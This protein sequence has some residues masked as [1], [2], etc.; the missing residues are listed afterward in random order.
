VSSPRARDYLLAHG[1]LRVEGSAVVW[2]G[3]PTADHE[4]HLGVFRSLAHP[5]GRA[6]SKKLPLGAPCEDAYDCSPG[7]GGCYKRPGEPV[8]YC[9]SFC[10]QGF[11]MCTEAGM[12]CKQPKVATNKFIATDICM[13]KK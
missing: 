7:L 5:L 4:D 9:T 13:K 3:T 12:V 10:H 8:G 6:L 11:P 1:A 2:R